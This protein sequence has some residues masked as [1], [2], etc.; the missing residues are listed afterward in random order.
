MAPEKLS[1]ELDRD[2]IVA[3][4]VAGIRAKERNCTLHRSGVT[5]RRDEQRLVRPSTSQHPADFLAE[6][7]GSQYQRLALRTQRRIGREQI[8]F[9]AH[10]GVA[11]VATIGPHSDDVRTVIFESE[12]NA[13]G[14]REPLGH[15]PKRLGVARLVILTIE[16]GEDPPDPVDH[17]QGLVRDRSSKA[18]VVVR[19]M[20]RHRWAL[21]GDAF[22]I[23]GRP[24]ELRLL[25]Q[26]RTTLASGPGVVWTRHRAEENR[27]NSTSCPARWS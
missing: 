19:R 1:A 21:N 26:V 22:P 18:R 15:E 17:S 27:W 4:V 5:D 23:G 20:R 9:E 3:L 11:Y 25:E 10:L 7:F 8:I 13:P 24:C 2:N 14:R 6:R 16:A 12:D